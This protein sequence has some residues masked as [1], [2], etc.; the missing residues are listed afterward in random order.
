MRVGRKPALMSEFGWVLGWGLEP[1]CQEVM[2]SVSSTAE[3]SVGALHLFT[4]QLFGMNSINGTVNYSSVNCAWLR[5]VTH[6]GHRVKSCRLSLLSGFCACFLALVPFF[7]CSSSF[8][9]S[10]SWWGVILLK[11]TGKEL[12]LPYLLFSLSARWLSPLSYSW[13]QVFITFN[14]LPVCFPSVILHFQEWRDCKP[15]AKSTSKESCLLTLSQCD[16]ELK[17]ILR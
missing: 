7:K 14:S 6:H 17:A 8:D 15:T 2:G 16:A 3:P 9:V 13:H 5:G 1:I 4:V 11:G 12:Q 10:R